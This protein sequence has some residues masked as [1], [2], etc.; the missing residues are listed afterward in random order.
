MR[1]WDFITNTFHRVNEIL[2]FEWCVWAHIEK[3]HP[4]KVWF[5]GGE[6]FSIKKFYLK[7]K[8]SLG[9]VLIPLY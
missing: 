4:Q 6:G 9:L 7:G 1:M 2:N 8:Q 5:G 3:Y